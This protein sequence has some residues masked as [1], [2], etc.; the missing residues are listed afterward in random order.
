[1][2]HFGSQPLRVFDTITSAKPSFLVVLPEVKTV[3]WCMF[4]DRENSGFLFVCLFCL[5][6]C[7]SLLGFDVEKL[8]QV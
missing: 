7:F 2:L 1:M 6:V 3:H 8:K 4:K 5:F